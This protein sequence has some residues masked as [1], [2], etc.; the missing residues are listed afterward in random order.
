M[1]REQLRLLA[2]D[3]ERLLGAGSNV[4]VGDTGLQ[5]RAKAL[6]ELSVKVPVLK[7][8]ADAVDQVTQAK[9]AEAGR[10][11]LDLLLIVRQVR[12][13]LTT[14]GAEGTLAPV[15]PSGPWA[16]P[17]SVHDVTLLRD[18]LLGTGESGFE[19]IKR[20]L[21]RK[22]FGDM[23]LVQPILDGLASSAYAPRSDL[24]AQEVIPSLGRALLPEL[25]QQFDLQGKSADARRLR[26]ICK[27]APEEG[28][29]LC[30][31]V[32]AE[33]S[34]EL[35]PVA[36]E[37]LADLVPAEAEV[38]G[39]EMLAKK[40]DQQFRAA[41]LRSLAHSTKDEAL[42][43]LLKG[44]SDTAEVWSPA[45]Q[46]LKLTPHPQ[47][48]PRLLTLLQEKLDAW[49]AVQTKKEPKE[50]ATATTKSKSKA[51]GPTREQQLADAKDEVHRVLLVLQTRHDPQAVP[52]LLPLLQHKD[53]EVRVWA[54]EAL[55]ATRDPKALDA[56]VPLI[57][58]SKEP[59]WQAAIQ[60]TIF[61]PPEQHFDILA[62]LAR[63]LFASKAGNAPA[64]AINTLL[65]NP[66]APHGEEYD[67]DYDAAVAMLSNVAQALSA[68]AGNVVDPTTV[69]AASGI[70]A[71]D[72][73][74][75]VWDSRWGPLL[76]ELLGQYAAASKGKDRNRYPV[77]LAQALVR[78]LGQDAL[79]HLLKALPV[80]VQAKDNN[81]IFALGELRR[82]EAA[83][84]LVEAMSHI[85]GEWYMFHA[86]NSALRSI[87]DK[88]VLPRL[89]ELRDAAKD[90]NH[91]RLLEY[92]IQ[93]LESVPEPTP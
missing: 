89:Y 76:V 21:E 56:I 81:F 82:K 52:D 61:L 23:R 15:P 5:K 26:A 1:P 69:L 44:I 37:M 78:V 13:S 93:N 4:A 60:A 88:S 43:A 16:T 30:R 65:M 42:E 35:K 91:Q 24:I 10:K 17:D 33:G 85:K 53:T 47:A 84:A 79:P 11:L 77:P 38:I 20:G 2:G 18:A 55:A 58:D 32:I 59:V 66:S 51:K 34:K 70:Q 57:E 86:I 92:I 12:A 74:P 68:V 83:P 31:K 25:R 45:H 67:E 73:R 41:A 9:S 7:Q 62:P 49:K 71:A 3:V 22:A 8:I 72:I 14:A 39:L 80:A 29:A 64:F 50:T 90:Q 40:P 87:G 63:N 75:H 28:A 48:T 46:A 6:R 19:E 36:L 27:I 54:I